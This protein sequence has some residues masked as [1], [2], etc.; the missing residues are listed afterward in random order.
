LDF[1]A[2]EMT[3]GRQ[4]SVQTAAMALLRQYG[5]DAG[6]IATLRAAEVAASGDAE[7]LAHWD[8]VIR[9]IEEGPELDTLN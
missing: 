6:V 1:G 9:W 3:A 2:L 8:A 7:A 5:D 4:S